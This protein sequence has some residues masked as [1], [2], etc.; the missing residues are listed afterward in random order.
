MDF[1]I[2]S[3]LVWYVYAK[4]KRW[5][6][7]LDLNWQSR[8]VQLVEFDYHAHLASKA[9]SMISS[10]SPSP[11]FRFSGIYYTRRGGL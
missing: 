10:K 8:A 4:L 3:V 7:N 2:R 1:N 11:A 6:F 9:G 5:V